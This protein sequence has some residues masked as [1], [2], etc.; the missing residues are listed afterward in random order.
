MA[1]NKT[2]WS[3]KGKTVIITGANTGIGKATALRLSKKGANITLACRSIDRGKKAVDDI[4]RDL[5][6]EEIEGCSLEVSH[7]DLGDLDT[8]KKFAD[9]FKEKH[10]RLD[11]LINNAGVI[12]NKYQE[13]KQG[14]ELMWATNHLGHFYLTNLL[15]DLIVASAPSRII[16]VASDA[17][18]FSPF[19]LKQ[20]IS[21]KK[22]DWGIAESMKFYGHTKTCNILHCIQLDKILKSKGIE[23]VTVNCLHPGTVNTDLSRNTPAAIAWLVKGAMRIF[24]RTPYQ[25]ADSSF[26]LAT[27]DEV[28]NITGKFFSEKG[29]LDTPKPYAVDEKIAKELWDLSEKAVTDR[30]L[31]KDKEELL[32]EEKE[33]V[34][35]KK[36]EDKEEKEG[37]KSKD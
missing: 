18:H 37:L 10:K 29:K 13:S 28:S 16:I 9:E 19:L 5:T 31:R 22:G 24:T 3:I 15:L 33:V 27:S 2:A 17:H 23:N 21:P 11:V 4:L 36:D 8:V 14:I 20:V 34:K 1:D 26:Y 12:I 35:G 6:P 30:G 25:G 32:S 7:L